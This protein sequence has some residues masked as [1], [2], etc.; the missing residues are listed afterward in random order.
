M[1]LPA[2]PPPWAQTFATAS[3]EKILKIIRLAAPETGRSDRYLH[4]DELRHRPAPDGLNPGEWWTGLK[5][6][7]TANQQ[8]L[9]LL[10]KKGAPFMFSLTRGMFG[11]LQEIDRRCSG[12]VEMPDSVTNLE[13]RDRYYMSSLVEEAITSSQLEGAVVTRAVAKE[14]L[15]TGR[16]PTDEGERMILNNY[17][18]M[19]AISTWKTEAL[20]PE[21]V[22][23]MHGMISHGTLERPEQEGRLRRPEE[24]VRVEDESTGE[25]MH[26]PPPARQLEK[27]LKALCT[28][29]NESRTDGFLHPVLRAIILH[30]WLAYDHPFVDGN[31]RTARALFYWSMLRQG[32]WLFE[33]I[34][35]SQTILKAPA[36]YYRAFL[37]SETDGNDLNYFLLNQLDSISDA[38]ESLHR[39]IRQKTS[40]IAEMRALLGQIPDFNARQMAL[41]KH[42][43]KHPG[44]LYTVASHRNSHGVVPQ[45]ARTDL[46]ELT[47]KGFL[48]K[49][50]RGKTFIFEG[51]SDLQNR[52][53]TL[54]H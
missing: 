5:L 24:L 16:A 42:A 23:A 7:R 6:A 44:A 18:T 53:T 36:S 8:A 21:L 29:A 51:V 38:V 26:Y 4:W 27:R 33:F 22:L 50:K 31:G 46:L 12:M 34:S 35:I 39:Y 25:V 20:T 11:R 19:R 37:Y 2:I 9:P 54:K 43:L 45:T 3:P 47:A 17:R 14:M 52:L 28:F 13:T 49:R 40:E 15:R 41:L 32:F 1:K 30:F 10:D 48:T